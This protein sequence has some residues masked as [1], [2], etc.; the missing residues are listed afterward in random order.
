MGDY[1][2]P[3]LSVAQAALVVVGSLVLAGAVK[4]TRVGK[5]VIIP[6]LIAVAVILVIYGAARTRIPVNSAGE[7]AGIVA[8]SGLVG[9]VVGVVVGRATE[10][11]RQL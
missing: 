4:G 8:F 10:Q 3:G 11:K 2:I 6:C 5:R 1:F 9:F 7:L